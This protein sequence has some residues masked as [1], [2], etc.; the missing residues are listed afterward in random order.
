MRSYKLSLSIFF[1]CLFSCFDGILYT[2]PEAVESPLMIKT[3]KERS[4]ETDSCKL[5]S[6]LAPPVCFK[7]GYADDFAPSV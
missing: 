7:C 1:Y 6:S 3:K 5:Q 4:T 2:V